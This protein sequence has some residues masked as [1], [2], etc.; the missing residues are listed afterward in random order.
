MWKISHAPIRPQDL[1]KLQNRQINHYKCVCGQ[2]RSV[3][4]D[5]LWKLKMQCQRSDVVIC[6][7]KSCIISPFLSMAAS[8]VADGFLQ[9]SVGGCTSC[10][11][12]SLCPDLTRSLILPKAAERMPHKLCKIS[13]RSAQR[14]G[15]N[16]RKTHG[17]V[18][19]PPLHG[20]GLSSVPILIATIKVWYSNGVST[21]CSHSVT[22]ISKSHFHC[23]LN[24][25]GLTHFR[26]WVFTLRLPG[27][28][29]V[30][31]QR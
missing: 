23:L 26:H 10:D 29:P 22:T 5:D 13:A 6:W 1:K 4:S 28:V 31:L 7:P 11:V 3:T 12:I 27:C 2:P 8:Y 16:S 18:S 20:R 21:L 17:G 24:N 25:I 19:P 14:F 30:L 15:G 9:K